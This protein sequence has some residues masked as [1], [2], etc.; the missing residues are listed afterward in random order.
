MNDVPALIPPGGS[1]L[2]GK[3]E[4]YI[5]GA[6]GHALM[7]LETDRHMITIAGMGGGKGRSVAITNLLDHPGSIFSVEIGGASFMTSH[8]VRQAV[9]KQDI[10]VFDPFGATGHS[11]VKLNVLDMLDPDSPDFITRV[12]GMAR[13]LIEDSEGLKESNPYW[14]RTP[15]ALLR[16]LI[17]YTK[18]SPDVDDKDR[19]L[20]FISSLLAKYP[21]ESWDELMESFA[22]DTGKFRHT[23]N[24][25]GNYYKGVRDENVRSLVS[26]VEVPLNFTQDPAISKLLTESSVDLRDLRKNPT[27][28]Y[29]VMK[30]M[31]DYRENATWLRLMIESAF[32]AC[33]NDTN[34]GKNHRQRDRVLFMLDEFTQLGKLQA[35][36]TGMVTA[37]QKG[38]TIWSLFQDI[39]RLEKLYGKEIADSF[40]GGAGA[41]QVFEIGDEP[42][43]EYVSKRAGKRI[44]LIPQVTHGLSYGQ[45]SQKN[46]SQTDSLG[47]QESL[48]E[49]IALSDT[50][51]WQHTD[52]IGTAHTTGTAHTSG[53]TTTT[54]MSFG[55]N[56]YSGSSYGSLF[57]TNSG[58]GSSS[59]FQSSTSHTDQ[60][61]TSESTTHQ[62]SASDSQGGS[63]G[64]TDSE[65]RTKG[66]NRQ[67]SDQHGE[68][69]GENRGATYQVSYTPHILP[70][71]EPYQ[72]EQI[73][74]TQNRQIIFVRSGGIVRTIIDQRANFDQIP[75][76]RRR[77]YGPEKPDI[78]PKIEP[79]RKPV[80][81]T[82]MRV[83]IPAMPLVMPAVSFDRPIPDFSKVANEHSLQARRIAEAHQNTEYSKNTAGRGR[84]GEKVI[85]DAKEKEV[86]IIMGSVPAIKQAE[87][88][89][90]KKITEWRKH[91]RT[92]RAAITT[93]ETAI[94]AKESKLDEKIAA[95]RIFADKLTKYERKAEEYKQDL[96]S[97]MTHLSG[98]KS[99]SEA[100]HDFLR[101]YGVWRETW[102]DMEEPEKPEERQIAGTRPKDMREVAAVINKEV[103]VLKPSIPAL[104]APLTKPH[105]AAVRQETLASP[106]ETIHTLKVWPDKQKR[107]AP[108]TLAELEHDIARMQGSKKADSLWARTYQAVMSFFGRLDNQTLAEYRQSKY[109]LARQSFDKISGNVSSAREKNAALNKD[110]KR[111]VESWQAHY[112]KLV[113]RNAAL[114]ELTERLKSAIKIMQRHKENLDALAP[115][116]HQANQTL[117][118]ERGKVINEI[119]GWDIWNHL[120][121]QT[122]RLTARPD[123]EP[124]VDADVEERKTTRSFDNLNETHHRKSGS[125][126]RS[127][128]P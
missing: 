60:T 119:R 34:A 46:W 109:S 57:S 12:K 21:S 125:A 84:K 24:P 41:V 95:A 79:L 58:R 38:I 7:R 29:I 99:G 71:L 48:T 80:F 127:P 87:D 30:E 36:E 49:G 18:T 45:N 27:S 123:A 63:K 10:H 5:I 23:L 117:E 120:H 54:G 108:R 72:V 3:E 26:S 107:H 83:E 37:R 22:L 106:Q 69:Y 124:V 9:L 44:A 113:Q 8:K 98:M 52:T 19:H 105:I 110:M 28:I 81:L 115:A 121:D 96:L 33:P 114:D 103:P 25:V 6:R 94:A 14:T 116:Y 13:S 91:W 67:R 85:L 20:P 31:E 126:G 11:S 15:Q 86:A 77:A 76:L 1:D 55:T 2:L 56:S 73:L 112:E 62:R 92:Q 35:I 88:D 51:T 59:T 50:E 82:D 64:R 68:S 93:L 70:S 40:F 89:F 42:T 78:I 32:A 90:S 104:P 16:A 74:G 111:E 97:D 102:T 4:G 66:S 75:A 65:S 17:V 118:Y 53:T 39:P 100:F 122:R 47:I 61:T 43:K 128:S 101:F